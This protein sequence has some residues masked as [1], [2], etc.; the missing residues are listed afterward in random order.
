V[1][2]GLGDSDM[3]K[4]PQ[5]GGSGLT[6]ALGNAVHAACLD[7]IQ[8]MVD[9]ASKDKRS[10]LHGCTVQTVEIRNGGIHRLG[11][12][13]EHESFTDILDRN[14]LKELTREGASEPPSTETMARAGSFGAHFVEVRVDPDLGTVRVERVVSVVDGGRILNEK[15]ARSQIIGGIVGGIGM[16]LLEE[17][18]S[19]KGRPINTSFGD[20]LIPVNADVPEIDVSFVGGPDPMTKVGA[21]GIGELAVTGVAAAIANAVFHATGKRIRSLPLSLDKVMD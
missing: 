2:V 1:H 21:K 15:V 18:V 16:A 13:E 17:T 19:I 3:P 4:A 12:P 14:G 8:A 20:Y 10:P 11:K 6:A 7:V 5:Q 9:L